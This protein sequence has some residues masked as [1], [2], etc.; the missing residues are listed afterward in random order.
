MQ[1]Q[2]WD[3]A[4]EDLQGAIRL[5]PTAIPEWY[6]NLAIAH[7][8]RKDWNAA[9][10]AI[11]R[12]LAHRGEAGWY[13]T[14]AGLNLK[15]G[16]LAAAK[17]DFQKA[18]EMEP[19]G[20]K[21]ERLASDYV[22]LGHLQH[23]AGEYQAAL[24]SCDEAQNVVPDYLPAYRQRAETLLA[25]ERPT[26]ASKAL[27]RYLLLAKSAP[28]LDK[29]Y[30]ARGLI[31]ARVLEP[32]KAVDAYTR[33]LALH[34][35]ANT[36][37]YR[38]WAY[39]QLDP[40]RAALSDFESAL[41]LLDAGQPA[42]MN[43]DELRKANAV[44]SDALCGRGQARVRLG[45]VREAVQDAEEALKQ[46]KPSQALFFSAACIYVRAVG[47][48]KAQTDGQASSAETV[49]QYRKRAI[50]LL[51]ATLDRVPVAGRKAF[52]RDIRKDST[53][54]AIRDSPAFKELDRNSAPD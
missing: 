46:G 3:S 28:D 47:Q 29:V 12:A 6:V 4:V 19:A 1:L 50:E 53:F 5:E 10:Q 42:L 21:S 23:L 49:S 17:K 31:R 39:L 44:R 43:P 52:W 45:Q 51:Q 35:E 41:Q 20:S 25:L 18:I 40:A 9:V 38:G 15:R 22:E 27:D 14:R 24:K 7:E 36:L 26:E 33:S 48:L 2:R 34:T 8:G 32:D 11:D 30:L 54:D 13:H 37:V 16:D